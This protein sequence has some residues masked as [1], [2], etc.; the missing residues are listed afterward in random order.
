MTAIQTLSKRVALVTGAS[1]GIGRAIARR[2]AAQGA[3]VVVSASPR[4]ES[5]LRETC[6]LISAAGGQA[7]AVV[8]DLADASMR[9]EL[10]SR[11][12][13]A[14]GAIDILVN[15]AAT[16]TAYAPPS[17]IDAAA[18]QAMFE[19]NF[20][21]PVDLIQ[22]AVPGMLERG[23]GRVLNISS[24]TA[25][26][27]AIPYPGPAKFVHALTLYGCSKSALERYTLGLAA[28]LHGSGVGVNALMPYK[29]AHSE[30]AAEIAQRMSAAHPDWVEPV[31]MM[32]EAAYQLISGTHTGWIAVSRDVLQRLQVPLLALDGA[33]PLGDA[34]TLDTL[35]RR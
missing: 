30:S 31:E 1:R 12:A 13:A 27:P 16:I 17:R 22:Q 20:H 18:R 8:T 5:G 24:E 14:F 34:L 33:T 4:S 7:A 9:A 11:A 26:Q 25:R 10:V 15:N 23:W 35:I 28:E 21:A 19:I 6:E 32:A 3:S 2:L 29:I